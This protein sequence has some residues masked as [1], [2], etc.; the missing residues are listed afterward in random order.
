[1]F[2]APGFSRTA[3]W[4]VVSASIIIVIAGMRVFS[5]QLS[6]FLM[7]ALIAMLCAPLQAHLQ[8]RGLSAG[9][10]LT[11]VLALILVL[12]VA[13]VAFIG[14]STNQLIHKLPDYQDQLH[15]MEAT[16][17]AQLDQ[18]GLSEQTVAAVESIDLQSLF[19]FVS[20]LLRATVD[21]LGSVLLV[22]LILLYMLIDAPH[23]PGRLRAVLD[24]ESRWLERAG[25]FIASVQRYMILKT[26][27]GV[28]I[29]AI[30]TVVMVIM[31]VDFAVQ[32]GVLAVIANYIP[33][34]G[35]VLG[36]IPPV[37][38]T[39]LEKGPAM[40]VLLLVVYSAI[41]NIIENWVAPRFMAEELGISSLFIFLSL[42]FWTWVLGAAGALLAVP[43]TLLVKI[44]L[45]EAEQGARGLVALISEGKLETADAPEA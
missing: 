8:R 24:S 12:G 21:S 9:L 23:I 1:M 30:Q 37:A 14:I 11:L 38:V 3:R 33:N 19:P 2:A 10:S 29:A 39:L 32:W 6:A 35:F 5:E 16:V 28:I 31:G 25:T 7:A 44:M 15:Q 45:L 34:I 27:F 41:N 4:L 20:G 13:L 43:L 18:F 42:I 22:F 40:A 17:W 36:V 26:V